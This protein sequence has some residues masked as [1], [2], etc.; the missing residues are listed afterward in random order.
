MR[1]LPATSFLLPHPRTLTAF[2][3]LW[4]ATSCTLPAQLPATRLD[5]VFPAGG[6]P[7]TTV[8]VTI[9]GTN[10]DDVDQLIFNH[11]G[12]TAARKMAEPTPF[13]DGPQPVDNVFMVTIA[14]DVPAGIYDLRCH[15]K[16]GR[17]NRRTFEVGSIAE[18]V[19][20]EPNGGNDIPEWI[21]TETGRTNAAQ[22][23]TL[24]VTVNGQ[25][26]SGPDVDWYRF[27]GKSGQRILLDGFCRRIDS[28]M[29]LMMTVMTANGQVLGESRSGTA[30]DSIVDV[31]L[32]ADGEYFVKVHDALF[33]QGPGYVYRIVIAAKPYVD[34]IFPPTGVP[35][36]ETDF[37]IYGR[38]LPG[39]Q[40]SSL[41]L[42]GRPLEQL[43]VRILMP[44]DVR[45][46][47]PVSS[48][49]SSHQGGL[50]AIDYR[51][52][53]GPMSSNPVF[54]IA[55]DIVSQQET[56]NDDPKA[57][58]LLSPPCAIAGQFYPQRDVD[59]YQFN[60]KKD[61]EW[62]IDV[63]SQ[64]LGYPSDPAL[65]VQ[66]AVTD[67]KGEVTYRDVSFVDDVQERNFNN[68]AG[69]H[70]FDE[71]S[72]DPALPFKAPA[73]GTYRVM[74]RDGISAVRSDPRLV[75]QLEIRKAKP[76][77][78]V[79]AVPSESYGSLMLRKGGRATIHLV[80]F[81]NDGYSEE[82]RVT[83]SGLPEGVT[84]EEVVIGPGNDYGT[85]VLS[86]SDSAKGVSSL[87]IA[88]KGKVN[89]AE[90]TRSVRYGSAVQSFQ[91]NQPNAN[92]P[93]VP[94]R[95][96]SDLQVCVSENE[97]APQTLTI[98]A[99]DGKVL[100]MS[101]G[102]VLKI[103]Y[104][105][106]RSEGSAGNLTGFPLNFPPNTNAQQVNIGTAE[107]G[108]FELRF[109][110]TTIPGT[111]SIVLAGFNQGMQYRRNPELAD[112]ARTRQERIAK[113]LSDAQQKTQQATQL[114]QQR[115]TEL[116]Q[117]TTQ[118]TQ[119]T[120][121]KQQ[122]DQ[123]LAMAQTALQQAD[124]MLKQKTEQSAANPA[125]EALKTQVAQAQTMFD[126]AKKA[127]DDAKMAADDALK[128]FEE[129]TVVRKAAEE[130]RTKAQTELTEAQQFQQ[131]AQ[132]EKQRADQFANQKQQE[133]TLRGINADVPSNPILIR[134]VEFPIRVDSFPET[135][136]VN[137]GEK[138][139]LATTISRMF[140]FNGQVTVQFQPPGGVNGLSFPA[141]NV[142]DGQSQ[143][144]TEILAQ[145][146]ATP[147]AHDCT[148]RLQMNFNGQ[149]LVMERRLKVTVN[150]VRKP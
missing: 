45:G 1:T 100:E 143:G 81:R 92:L 44:G 19:E 18:F 108:E 35:G 88:A 95:L 11:A 52:A 111:Y 62:I 142:P 66:Q 141:L 53:A 118:L 61:E 117:A 21:V 123:K 139:E 22:E 113:I 60:A 134:V 149:N 135:L 120:T 14:A 73:D 116:T 89:D 146:T 86:A 41:Q 7:S 136:T 30:R 3:L 75:Y 90:V 65:L 10:L 68:R 114:N 51:L 87:Q 23:L 25:A 49:V 107:K 122:A 101:R 119:A 129:T 8:E 72:G 82:I 26:V 71:R 83:A 31:T 70:E 58:Q 98:G 28:R 9:A 42:D 46:R 47:L 33:G 91:F 133:A 17:S 97:S 147:G 24:P 144:K 115:Q 85:L 103:P 36:T 13:D 5:S 64:R 140:E 94:A 78:R 15:G 109:Q 145:P 67:D 63:L 39:G 138:T 93:S 128:K 27:T 16:Y 148:V 2:V 76:D 6:A 99:G 124:A 29:D 131:R 137:Q 126:A 43:N 79:I 102:G 112:K 74:L 54:V 130:A 55:S 48:I 132:Q 121:A 125:D 104:S 32:P 150:E 110:S 20:T 84:T 4:L 106:R 96:V 80:A 56:V 40:P 50:D 127:T 77:F 12:I 34:F 37:T 57:P 59:W 38:N 105:V 69:R